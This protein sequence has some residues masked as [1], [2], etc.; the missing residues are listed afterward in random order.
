[1]KYFFLFSLLY[2]LSCGTQKDVSVLSPATP[3]PSDATVEVIGVGQKVPDGAKL[4]GHV[5]IGDSG[6]STNCTYDKVVSDAQKQA[7]GMGGNLLQITKHK[8]PNIGSTCHRLECDVYVV[9]R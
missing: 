6:F 9:K 7:R 2:F 5:K 4:L 8:E 3:L 1:M